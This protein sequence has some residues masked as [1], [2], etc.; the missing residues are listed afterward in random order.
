MNP[1]GL[2]EDNGKMIM[3]RCLNICLGSHTIFC[4]VDYNLLYHSYKSNISVQM[5]QR[6]TKYIQI[7]RGNIPHR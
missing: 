7:H 3:E 6:L 2:R 1:P 4:R 5:N